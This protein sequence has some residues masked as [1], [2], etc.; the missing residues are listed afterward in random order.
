[1]LARAAPR[2]RPQPRP[3]EPRRPYRS[4]AQ[5]KADKGLLAGEKMKQEGNANRF[6]LAPSHDVRKTPFASYD[7]AFINAV[8]TRWLNILEER[9]FVG[10]DTGKVVLEF[11]LNYDGRILS[12]RVVESEVNELL[13][14]FCQRAV[15]DPAPYMPFP[16]DLRR[17]QKTDYRE[18]RFTF[19]YNQ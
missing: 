7:L 4:L 3:P 2:P 5:A 11:R 16:P 18:I 12:M 14:W 9:G 15:L 6:S 19:Y 8:Q 1:M 17:R 13:S 10:T